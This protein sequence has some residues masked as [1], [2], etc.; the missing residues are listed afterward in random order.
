MKK[1]YTES[2]LHTTWQ[3]NYYIVAQ[4]FRRQEI[5]III[6][7]CFIQIFWHDNLNY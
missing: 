7:K 3:Y 4:K 5:A 2:L 6:S 1:S